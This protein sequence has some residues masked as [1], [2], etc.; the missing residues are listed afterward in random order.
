MA[1][2]NDVNGVP[3]TEQDHV[4]NEILKGEWGWDGLVMSDWFATKTAGPAANGGLDLVMPGPDGPWGEALVRAVRSGE[5]AES[6]VDDH[7]R[8]VLR[9]AGRV[10]ALGPARSVPASLPAPD[11][12]VRRE[13]L[14]RLA[15]AGMT[16]LSNEGGTLPLRRG[17]R[18]ALIGRHA[19]DTVGMGGGSAQVNAAVPGERRGRVALAAR[20]RRSRSP[21][22]SRCGPGRCRRRPASSP[23]RTP[24][25]PG[26][27]SPCWTRAGR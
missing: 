16:V 15:A 1:A 11:S 27:G 20:R 9:L 21:T 4:I 26:S 25:S 6:V 18:V 3:A 17:Q 12:P 24:V 5:V 23:T 2:Y 7:L 8:R 19:L 14:T 10:G 13:Q 22:A